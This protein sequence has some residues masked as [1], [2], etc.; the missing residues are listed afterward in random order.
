MFLTEKKRFQTQGAELGASAVCAGCA[1]RG[2][3]GLLSGAQRPPLARGV[4][5]LHPPRPAPWSPSAPPGAARPQP[6][7]RKA[8][9]PAKGRWGPRVK[10]A[11]PAPPDR[12]QPRVPARLRMAGGVLSSCPAGNRGR[13][14]S[15]GPGHGT[16]LMP[17]LRLRGR[18]PWAG[19][20][21]GRMS[22]GQAVCPARPASR[23]G[24]HT[25]KLS[26]CAG[27]LWNR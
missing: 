7:A 14:R 8:G 9:H 19:G 16:C 15:G 11:P 25:S 18:V 1:G 6:C 21:G 27:T 17:A 26:R 24:G 10:S 3:G 12:P 5:S 23:E 4:P 2:A 20:A 13:R 22:Q